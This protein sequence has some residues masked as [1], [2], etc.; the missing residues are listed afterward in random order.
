MLTLMHFVVR[1]FPPQF[2]ALR[3]FV[4]AGVLHETH[5]RVRFFNFFFFEIAACG[6]SN[7]RFLSE[8]KIYMASCL[9]RC[10]SKMNSNL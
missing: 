6:A 4:F 7:N 10:R 8:D 9:R 2:L 1:R 5:F 3:S